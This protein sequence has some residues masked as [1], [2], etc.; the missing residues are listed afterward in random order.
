FKGFALILAP[1]NERVDEVLVL[2]EVEDGRING[3]RN[4][5]DEFVYGEAVRG[6]SSPRR[7]PVLALAPLL[8]V[9]LGF[10]FFSA[11]RLAAGLLLVALG[12]FFSAPRLA[13]V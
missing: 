11:P 10:G 6:K 2:S 7:H 8:P 3:L 4:P 12:F 13:R 1:S 9:A 5:K